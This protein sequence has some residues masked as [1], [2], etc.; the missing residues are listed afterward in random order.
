MERVRELAF[1]GV[2][3]WYPGDFPEL[4]QDEATSAERLAKILSDFARARL[5]L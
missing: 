1:Y 2:A 3:S 4:T 5:H